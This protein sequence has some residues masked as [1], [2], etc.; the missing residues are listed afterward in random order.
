[1]KPRT[2]LAFLLLLSLSVVFA[3]GVSAIDINDSDIVAYYTLDNSSVE[4]SGNWIDGTDSGVTYTGSSASFSFGDFIDVGDLESSDTTYSVGVKISG[5]ANA[6]ILIFPVSK[7]VSPNDYPYSIQIL[8]NGSFACAIRYSGSTY[9][10]VSSSTIDGSDLTTVLC[11]R[12]ATTLKINVDGVQENSAVV[13]SSVVSSASDTYMGDDTF[14]ASSAFVGNMSDFLF[15]D[16][17][18]NNSDAE[19][20]HLY[21]VIIDQNFNI[22]I[23]AT[24]AYNSSGISIFNATVTET[25]SLSPDSTTGTVDTRYLWNTPPKTDIIER[26]GIVANGT[27]STFAVLALCQAQNPIDIIVYD[28]GNVK[29]YDG[30]GY[31]T[32]GT[33]AA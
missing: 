11:I 25:G 22:T 15:I 18:L 32:L 10:T 16:R 28:N 2:V 5:S 20:F 9:T 6:S 23:T 3:G 12:D 29:C 24:D 33:V 27:G 8:T 14:S 17:A 1:M 4:Q 13:P 26:F 19:S 31:H 7:Y 30:I 21:G